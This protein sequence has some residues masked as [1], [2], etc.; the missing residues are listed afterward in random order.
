MKLFTFMIWLRCDS[1]FPPFE[2]PG[3]GFVLPIVIHLERHGVTP[4]QRFRVHLNLG[5]YQWMQWNHKYIYIANMERPGL[6]KRR[7]LQGLISVLYKNYIKLH[8]PSIKS[9]P[10]AE[11]HLRKC[12]ESTGVAFEAFSRFSVNGILISGIKGK[13]GKPIRPD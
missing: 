8:N 5:K 1:L 7:K 10:S 6:R 3:A 4:P 9:Y 2:Y 13:L 11:V 12:I